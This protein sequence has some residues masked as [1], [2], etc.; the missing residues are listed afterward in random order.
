MKTTESLNQK[1]CD[2][3]EKSLNSVRL[4]NHYDDDEDHLPLVDLLSTGETILEGKQEIENIVEQ[5]SFDLD[6]LD[7]ESEIT[8]KIEKIKAGVHDPNKKGYY[9]TKTIEDKWGIAYWDGIKFWDDPNQD[10]K[11]AF[12]IKR[13]FIKLWFTLPK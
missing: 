12:G 13:E 3:V 2:I 9:L 7:I 10:G 1:I 11:L 6:E 4:I 5:I 8:S